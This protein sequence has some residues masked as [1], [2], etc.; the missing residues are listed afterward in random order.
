[1]PQIADT[2]RRECATI[3]RKRPINFNLDRYLS[4]GE[5]PRTVPLP[6]T[7][8][9][10]VWSDIEDEPVMFTLSSFT[11]TTHTLLHLWSY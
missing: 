7:H 2:Q 10:D 6:T 3:N 9:L 5:G 1:M 11:A 4:V 8:P